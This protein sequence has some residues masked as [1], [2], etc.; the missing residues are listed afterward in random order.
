MAASSQTGIQKKYPRP[1]SIQ[2]A[3]YQGWLTQKYHTEGFLN[4][5]GSLL[6]RE[7]ELQ[8]SI[9]VSKSSRV[10]QHR[11]E[12]D[13]LYIKKYPWVG[14]KAFLQTLFF[15]AGKAQKSWR[16]GWLL[17]K[18]GIDTPLPLFYLRR[19]TEVFAG[20]HILATLGVENSMSLRDF[21]NRRVM[22]H[23]LIGRKKQMFIAK[24]AQFLGRLHL[25]GV[26]HGDLTARNILVAQGDDI[27]DARLFLIDLDAIRST[28]WISRRR[29]IKNLD[30]L[31]RNFLD[32][33]IISTCDRA[34]FLKHYLKS[35]SKETKNF[36]QL[37]K[38]VERRTMRRLVKHG[39]G[40][41]T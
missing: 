21:V 33:K 40:F 34:R 1:T 17:L 38:A 41:T 26:Y 12:G 10:Y 37:F 23:Q 32:L 7:E 28:R 3:G 19:R 27:Q 39:Q 35:C 4:H 11:Y 24:T 5:L 29:R 13:V 16:T 18:R 2:I 22:D 36:K 20:E 6:S 9:K 14:C 8:R 31:G 25:A 30:E 15:H